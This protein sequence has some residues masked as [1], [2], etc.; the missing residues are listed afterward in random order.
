MADAPVMA[1]HDPS[2]TVAKA[3][4]RGDPRLA[5]DSAPKT[6]MPGTR[7]GMTRVNISAVWY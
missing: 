1:A 2:K 7:P 4:A 3:L 5:F 6:W